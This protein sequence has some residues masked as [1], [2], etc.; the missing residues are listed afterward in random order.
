[1]IW[2]VGVGK[3][4]KWTGAKEFGQITSAN[5]MKFMWM[6]LEIKNACEMSIGK[7]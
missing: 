1:L 3:H 2:V 7:V 4:G 5:L 6:K